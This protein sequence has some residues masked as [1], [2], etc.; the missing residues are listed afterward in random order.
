M[1]EMFIKYKIVV[2]RTVGTLMLLV[3]FVVF[4]WA[5]QKEV[6]TENDIAA[7]NIARMEASISGASRSSKQAAKPDSSKFL[8]E[9]KNTQ[10][11]QMQ[12]LTIIT[13]ILGVGFL[14]YSFIGKPKN[15]SE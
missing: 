11:K 1:K 5:N 13:M 4:F 12:Y 6:I 15:D 2:F 3:G 7:A 8:E 9:L 14:G 10:A